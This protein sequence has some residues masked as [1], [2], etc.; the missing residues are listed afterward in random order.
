MTSAPTLGYVCSFSIYSDG[1]GRGEALISHYLTLT[2]QSISSYDVPFPIRCLY[3]SLI[4]QSSD[5]WMGPSTP[6]RNEKRLLAG[7]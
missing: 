3:G 4:L 6:H 7:S 1:R 5:V 2:D